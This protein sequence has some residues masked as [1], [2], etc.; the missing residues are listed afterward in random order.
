MENQSIAMCHKTLFGPVNI[1]HVI[2]WAEYHHRLGVDVIYLWYMPEM[3]NAPGF[4]NLRA[5]NYVRL[6][7]NGIATIVTDKSG[8][9]GIA[10]SMPGNQFDNED[11]CL[12]DVAKHHNWVMILDYDEFLWFHERIGIHDFVR[13]HGTK[14]NVTYLSFSKYMYST[15]TAV[16]SDSKTF[17]GVSEVRTNCASPFLSNFSMDSFP[18]PLG[19]IVWT[20]PTIQF[21]EATLSV[22][23]ITVFAK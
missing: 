16:Q 11:W 12:Q 14:R 22:Q 4:E 7:E 1:T 20:R 17:F 6:L 10:E 23:N 5:L 9:T 13:K 19:P 15:T 8:Y 21:F 18:S 3:V 2:N